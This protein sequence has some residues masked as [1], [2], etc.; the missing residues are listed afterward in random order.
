MNWPPSRPRSNFGRHLGI[1]FEALEIV[2]LDL[3]V[4]PDCVLIDG[5][6]AEFMRR[7]AHP[8][9]GV[10]MQGRIEVGPARPF[11]SPAWMISAPPLIRTTSVSV[12]TLP[13]KST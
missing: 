6:K 10:S 11:K 1:E 3:T 8:R 2:V 5:Q 4:K 7:D 13:S 9:D 12:T